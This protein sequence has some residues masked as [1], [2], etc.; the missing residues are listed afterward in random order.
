LLLRVFKAI[1]TEHLV[2]NVFELIA[3]FI[4]LL[5]GKIL[6]PGRKNDGVFTRRVILIHK[7]KWL[8]DSRQR[9]RSERRH[10]NLA[11]VGKNIVGNLAPALVLLREDIG[12]TRQLRPLLS[13][14]RKDVL[15]LEHA[16]VV[17]LAKSSEELG[18]LLKSR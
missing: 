16:L 1:F 2:L 11:G 18:R 7:D 9:P 10:F 4:E 13:N 12:V 3:D 6:L 15:L 8:H 17:I 14:Q 5:V